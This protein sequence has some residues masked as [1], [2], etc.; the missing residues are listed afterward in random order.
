[1]ITILPGVFDLLPQNETDLW[2]STYIWA[3]VEAQARE[4]AKN[5]GFSEIRTPILEKTELFIRGVGTSS[6]IITK[7]TYTFEDRGNRSV[8]LRPEGT[9]AV[10]RS[11][12]EN[13]LSEKAPFHKL[14]YIAP[15]FR[16]ERQQ[17]GRYRQHHQFGVEVI[18]IKGPEQDAEVMA[19]L[20]TFYKKLGL[21]NLRVELNSIGRGESRALYRVAL[22]D[23]LKHHFERLSKESQNRFEVNPLRILDSKDLNDREI[24]EKAPLIGDYL[25]KEEVAHLERVKEC[26]HLLEIPFEVNQKLVRGLDYYNETV[27][28]VV[29]GELGAQ[30]SIGAGGRYDGLIKNLGGKDLPSVGFGTGLERVVQTLIKQGGALPK[31]PS[32]SLYMIPLGEK[33]LNACFVLSQKLREEGVSVHLDFTGKKVAKSIEIADDMGAS[34]VLVLGEEELESGQIE[35]KE[36][37]R[38][39]KHKMSFSE[40]SATTL[41][42]KFSG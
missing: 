3:Y 20:Y 8:T 26:L 40:L 19:L 29:A 32:P 14:F 34:F 30:N 23:Y 18:G 17:A 31:K 28:E 15:M 27:F 10:I 12:I 6:D 9:A 16:Y 22:L 2:R 35:L 25:S 11:F 41:S 24:L 5:F 39:I 1:M 38:S 42:Q 7:E 21:K 37:G 36:M 13:H 33:A 4:C